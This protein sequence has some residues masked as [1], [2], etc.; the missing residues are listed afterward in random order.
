MDEFELDFTDPMKTASE[1]ADEKIKSVISKLSKWRSLAM[2]GAL[3]LIALVLPLASFDFVNP[4][5]VDF[6]INA[7]YSLVLATLCYYIFAPM[8]AR[9]ERLD[10]ITYKEARKAWLTL[11]KDVRE[12]KLL[13]AFFK[14]CKIRQEE[15]REERRDLY[16]EAASVPMEVYLNQYAGLS[17][18]EL[19]ALKKSGELTKKQVKYLNAANGEIK[20]KS[21]NASMIL[22]GLLM[23]NIND[24]GRIGGSRW[25]AA[26]KPIMLIF[27]M[28]V[29]GIIHVAGNTDLSFLDYLTSI[30]TTTSIILSWSFAGYRYGISKVHEEEQIMNG[31]S[32]FIRMF[33]ERHKVSEQCNSVEHNDLIEPQPTADAL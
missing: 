5:S 3:L 25:L 16:V 31:R 32:E 23:N 14:F 30:M 20:V 12:D 28:I 21:I 1:Q 2:M 9:A 15:E 17:K 7:V 8:S 18:K 10:S 6:M 22:S 27:T 24:V 13:T 29:R 19:K 33:Y 11:S 26:I 4:I